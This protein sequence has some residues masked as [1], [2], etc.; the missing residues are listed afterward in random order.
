MVKQVEV[1]A[2]EGEEIVQKT[3]EIFENIKKVCRRDG[4]ADRAGCWFK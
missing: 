2:R 3:G 4:Y 1:K